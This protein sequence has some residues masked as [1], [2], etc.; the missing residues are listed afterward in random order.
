MI[1]G[2]K[3]GIILRVLL[4]T[5]TLFLLIYLVFETSYY[6]SLALLTLLIGY[7]V[8]NLIQFVETTNKQLKRFLEAIS[9]SD[10]SQNFAAGQFDGSMASLNEAFNDIIEKFKQE[11]A[12]GE[13]SHR[14]LQTVVQHIGIGL[15]SFDQTGYVE[16]IN[17]AAKRLLDL[18]RL[19][20]VHQLQESHPQVFTAVKNLGNGE[21]TLINFIQNDQRMQL[22]AYATEFKMKG[23]KYKLIS[24]QNINEEL[25]EKEMEAWQNLTQVLAHE[26]MNSITPIAS[27]SDTV[28][29]MLSENLS[30]GQNNQHLT[31]D[32]VRDVKEALSTIHNRSLGLMRFVNSYRNFTQIPTPSFEQISV[33]ELLKRVSSLMKGE[34]KASGIDVR[35]SVDPESLEITADPQLIEQALINLVKNAFVALSKTEHPILK[36]V[37][38]LDRNGR[39]V[40]EV[41]DN[42]PGIKKSVAEKIFVPFYT[43]RPTGTERGT[44]IGLSLSR[45]IMRLHNGSL[46]LNTDEDTGTKFIMR[47]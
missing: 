1:K 32:T 28:N 40:I 2:F 24:L 9:Y 42:G 26:I 11:R 20:Y 6:V 10:F 4:L 30:P 21:Q 5:G 16:F 27:L 37:G 18:P 19:T 38:K 34:A 36:L 47:F 13:E 45:Q 29:S 25:E 39:T 3:T 35:V 44:G 46:T 43:T 14:Y 23:S 33:I 22:S 7:Q 31:E 8:Y 41:I 15:F 17:T 12:A